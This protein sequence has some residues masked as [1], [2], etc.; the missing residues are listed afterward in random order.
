MPIR[1][2]H[3]VPGRK[4]I[5]EPLGLD[6]DL[7]VVLAFRGDTEEAR[8][9]VLCGFEHPAGSELSAAVRAGGARTGRHNEPRARFKETNE[10][11]REETGKWRAYLLGQWVGGSRSAYEKPEPTHSWVSVRKTGSLPFIL[12]RRKPY[13][14]RAATPRL[15]VAKASARARASGHSPQTKLSTPIDT[16]HQSPVTNHQSP[17]HR[18][19]ELHHFATQRLPNP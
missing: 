12:S 8:G 11:G 7:E 5:V 9:E 10:G 15:T 17:N 14:M 18:P 2:T 3:R 13:L 6:H 16:S 19:T 1:F 4:R